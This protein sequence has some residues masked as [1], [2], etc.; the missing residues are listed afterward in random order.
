MLDGFNIGF[1]A[2]FLL[3]C[4]LKL[5]A[6]KPK[7]RVID[8]VVQSHYKGG[9]ESGE[10]RKGRKVGSHRG[11]LECI[12]KLIAFKPKVR[13]IDAVVQSHYKGGGESGE[14]RKG[15]KVGSHR[16]YLECILNLIAFK[17]KE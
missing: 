1:T 12:L 6:F 4:I 11:Y 17:P 3:E 14:S 15:R 9:G 2:V 7:V 5:I 10:S 16:G 13:V 8:A